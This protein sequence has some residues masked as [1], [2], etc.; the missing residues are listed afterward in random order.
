[1]T[2]R[3]VGDVTHSVLKQC[4]VLCHGGLRFVGGGAAGE[5]REAHTVAEGLAHAV[6][7]GNIMLTVEHL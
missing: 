7:A 2:I 6:P 3:C 1:V 5:R 4:T